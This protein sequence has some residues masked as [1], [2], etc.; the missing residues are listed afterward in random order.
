MATKATAVHVK[1]FFGYEN[2]QAFMTE[3]RELS[4]ELKD[5]FCDELGKEIDAGRFDPA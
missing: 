3:W 2:A 5:W 4:Q 1:K